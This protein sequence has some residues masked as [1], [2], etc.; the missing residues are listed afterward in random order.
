MSATARAAAIAAFF[1]LVLVGLL[2]GGD[3]RAATATSYGKI[4]AG[5]GAVY[6]VLRELGVPVARSFAEPGE[7]APG[8]TIWWIEPDE[9]CAALADP[10]FGDWLRAGGTA[11]VLLGGRQ[12]ACAADAELAG[13]AVPARPGCECDAPRLPDGV[14]EEVEA[15]EKEL[16]L[17]A[18]DGPMADAERSPYPKR[19]TVAGALLRAPRALELDAPIAFAPENEW[20]AAAAA[21]A[22]KIVATQD[23][24]PWALE[25]GLE[26]G[27]LVVVADGRFLENRN[28]DRADGAPLA[29]DLVL[30]LGA[31]WIDERA[32]GLVPS[33]DTLAYLAGSPAAPAFAGLLVAALVFAW[34]GSSEPPRRVAE[35]D[36]DAPTLATYVESLA[37]LYG[38]TGD[39]ARV[40]DRYREVSARRLRR[41]LGLPPDTSL[42][43]LLDRLGRRRRLAAEGVAELRSAEPARSA[44]DLARRAAILDRLVEEASR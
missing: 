12:S 21:A 38:A 15:L 22:W 14:E 19:V 34:Y 23:G 43:A 40:L 11:V 33:R 42:A 25:R 30:A 36:A 7:L 37:G 29:V 8:R 39:H 18:E 20:S 32:H 41:S 9:G 35:L 6:D 17:G 4:G 24:A 5:H 3:E 31:P 10:A 2:T 28:L 44:A 26:N 27:R 1:A 16:G 13:A